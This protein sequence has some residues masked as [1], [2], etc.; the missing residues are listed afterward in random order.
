VQVLC[1]NTVYFLDD[2]LNIKIYLGSLKLLIKLR[3]LNLFAPQLNAQ[4][5]VQET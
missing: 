4:S 1:A 3:N 5:G 2:L